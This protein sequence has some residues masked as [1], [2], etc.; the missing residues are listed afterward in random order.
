MLH[1]ENLS[2]SP[3]ETEDAARL[4]I[5]LGVDDRERVKTALRTV[6]AKSR[7]EQITFDRVF[8]G[9]FSRRNRSAVRPRSRW[10]GSRSWSST[11]GKRRRSFS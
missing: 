7:E 8:D 3:K 5:A 9:F 11:A 10:S 4:L 2:V 1:L 6:Y